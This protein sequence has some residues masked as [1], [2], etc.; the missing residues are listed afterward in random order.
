MFFPKKFFRENSQV[1]FDPERLPLIESPVLFSIVPLKNISYFNNE[2]ISKFPQPVFI[3]CYKGVC[4]L[5]NRSRRNWQRWEL[6]NDSVSCPA[7]N[8]IALLCCV[9]LSWILARANRCWAGCQPA[10]QTQDRRILTRCPWLRIEENCFFVLQTGRTL[11]LLV[12][13][14]NAAPTQWRLV[15]LPTA[16]KRSTSLAFTP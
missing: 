6:R 11:L 9:V 4:C 3:L 1:C 2:Y 7:L 8:G 12:V 16:F 15:I 10:R 14:L 5:F 13:W